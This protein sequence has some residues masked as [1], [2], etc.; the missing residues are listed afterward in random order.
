LKDLLGSIAH[1]K[2]VFSDL[3]SSLLARQ[4][5][6]EL[7]IAGLHARLEELKRIL[8]AAMDL[9]VME[10][11]TCRCTPDLGSSNDAGEFAKLHAGGVRQLPV[12]ES[13]FNN[14]GRQKDEVHGR[15][16]SVQRA[17]R[18]LE[19]Y[20]GGHTDMLGA[21]DGELAEVRKLLAA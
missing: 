21:I 20:S 4:S 2:R 6:E 5:A 9:C 8:P 17:L 14:A 16:D 15:M 18:R 11:G 19:Q 7:E 10:A 12:L 3:A 1:T 13:Q